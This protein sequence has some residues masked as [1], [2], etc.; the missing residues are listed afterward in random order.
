MVEEFLDPA[1]VFALLRGSNRHLA[2]ILITALN[3]FA[4]RRENSLHVTFW[5]AFYGHRDLLGMMLKEG[6]IELR[7]PRFL[8]GSGHSGL[9][10]YAMRNSLRLR[11]RNG[12]ERDWT[13]LWWALSSPPHVR[14]ERVEKVVGSGVQYGG[15]VFSWVTWGPLKDRDS[16]EDLRD[17]LNSATLD[18]LLRNL[19]VEK[20]GGIFKRLHSSGRPPILKAIFAG[21]RRV[22][23]LFLK[24]GVDPNVGLELAGRAPLHLAADCGHVGVAGT[25][26]DYGAHIDRHNVDSLT[27]LHF[28]VYKKRRE[29]IEFLVSKGAPLGGFDATGNTLLGFAVQNCDPT[30]VEMLVSLEV[31]INQ[32][33]HKD[34]PSSRPIHVAVERGDINMV[35]VLVRL[36][37]DIEA[38][39]VRGTPLMMAAEMGHDELLRMLIRS[40]AN[41]HLTD[42]EGATLMHIA[43]RGGREST[44]VALV[45]MMGIG[46]I[47]LRD[48]LGGTPMRRA[49]EGGHVPVVRRLFRLGADVNAERR[50]D[51]CS[52]LSL[53]IGVGSADTVFT[54]TY[55]TGQRDSAG[56]RDTR[57]LCSRTPLSKMAKIKG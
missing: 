19:P 13:M 45:E 20:L 54:L 14:L 57:Q 46:W 43:A 41:P 16:D 51:G 49:V 39:S 26:L 10:D 15:D 1:D 33:C 21:H 22:V 50:R 38:P 44:V 25:L 18:L 35:E 12:I 28:A 7:H 52:P 37:A 24:Y 32:Q 27:P 5:A 4:V 53:D 36:K 17:Q 30:I 55:P 3:S 48:S 40:G 6:E 23:E 56:N 31:D 9:V 42:S 47:Y 34:Y 29:M 11:V 2:P 8:P